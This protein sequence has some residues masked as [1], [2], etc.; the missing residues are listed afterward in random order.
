MSYTEHKE[1]LNILSVFPKVKSKKGSPA[2]YVLLEEFSLLI[3][4]EKKNK[5]KVFCSGFCE[6]CTTEN[7]VKTIEKAK[8]YLANKSVLDEVVFEKILKEYLE[9]RN[10]NTPTKGTCTI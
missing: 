1:I 10:E 2:F 9:Q 5:F 6:Y 7:L 3:S 4:R 8:I